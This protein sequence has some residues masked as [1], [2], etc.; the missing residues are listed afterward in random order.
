MKRREIEVLRKRVSCG[1]VLERAGFAIDVKETTRRAVKFRR[2]VEDGVQQ[3]QT[4]R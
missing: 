1:A 2:G 4:W 3:A